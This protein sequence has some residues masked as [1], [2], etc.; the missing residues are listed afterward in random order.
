MSK[1]ELDDV[2]SGYNLS[3][4]NTNFQKIATELNNKTL[5]RDNPDG[6][7][8][9]ME[10]TLDM[11]LNRIIN[12][13]APTQS[14]EA[15]RLSDVQGFISNAP[16]VTSSSTGVKG[17]VAYDAAFLYVCIATNSWKRIALASF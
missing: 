2:P 17:T 1:I 7:P 15:A 4:I 8:N 11:N 10:S 12:L 13:P 6:E 16:P 5:Y 14:S 9:Q 3:K